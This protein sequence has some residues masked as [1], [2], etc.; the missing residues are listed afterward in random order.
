MF[1]GNDFDFDLSP[2]D[3]AI[4]KARVKYPE[5]PV[6]ELR[7]ILE[8]EFDISLSHNRVNEILNE[9]RAEGVF[10]M[11]AVPNRNIFEYYLFQVAFHYSNFEENWEGCYKRLLDDP[12]VVLFCSADDYHE[13]QFVAQF[14]SAEESEEWRHEF[15]KEYGNFVAQIDKTAFPTVHKFETA[16]AVFDDLLSDMGGEQYVDEG[17]QEAKEVQDGDW[18]S[19]N[20]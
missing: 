12:H 20:Q 7:D 16:A 14:A 8:S 10:S 1:S 3:V 6:S 19:V 17:E 4:L 15:V 11:Q 2:R 18:I 5:K 9:M 13:W